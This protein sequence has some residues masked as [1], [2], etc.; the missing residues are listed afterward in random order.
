MLS[1]AS[2][3]HK[4]PP[5]KQPKAPNS[6][7]KPL[8]IVAREMF[9][10]HVANGVKVADAYTLSGYR[11]GPRDR[12]AIRN[13][14]EVAARINFLLERRVQLSAQAALRP[15]K[16]LGDLRLRVLRKLERIALGDIRQVANWS[17]RPILDADGNL[18]GF[19]DVVDITPSARL[20]HDAAAAVK[21]VFVKAGEVRL[22][23]HDPQPALEKLCKA[24]GIYADAAPAPAT[25]NQVNVGT[26]AGETVKR[27][28]FLLAAAAAQ[29]AKPEPLT[30]EGKRTPPA[31][32]QSEVT[33]RES[34]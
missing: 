29:R 19:Q 5:R 11:G 9:A 28:A 21:G 4:T 1:A 22:E 16:Q 31:V 10:Q 6:P 32:D 26:D 13:A 20:T 25:V 27:I 23:L 12:W 3:T 7:G 34:K 30:I 14:R 24:L 18:T 15:E 2:P 17:K 33:S 8:K